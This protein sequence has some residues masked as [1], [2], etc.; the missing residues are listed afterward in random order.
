R[1]FAE[2]LQGHLSR[3]NCCCL[4]NPEYSGELS[5]SDNACGSRHPSARVVASNLRTSQ[6]VIAAH[7]RCIGSNLPNP[8]GSA[9]ESCDQGNT[10]AFG[11]GSAGDGGQGYSRVPRVVSGGLLG[12]FEVLKRFSKVLFELPLLLRRYFAAIL[13]VGF[14]KL[15]AILLDYIIELTAGSTADTIYEAAAN[16]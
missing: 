12:L 2:L 11:G 13:L 3:L 15:P 5:R 1:L 10:A 16:A 14:G 9:Q 7:D 8:C 6:I 4:T